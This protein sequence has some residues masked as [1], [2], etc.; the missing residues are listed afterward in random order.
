MRSVVGCGSTERSRSPPAA[1]CLPFDAVDHRDWCYL[2]FQS[3]DIV[4]N[5]AGNGDRIDGRTILEDT[6]DWS[7]GQS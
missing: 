4:P 2:G 3:A 7:V 1:M 6:L 5:R